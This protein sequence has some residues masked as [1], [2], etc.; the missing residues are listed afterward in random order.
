MTVPATR[1]RAWRPTFGRSPAG[2]PPEGD[3]A[4]LRRAERA[5][6]RHF[7]LHL[8]LG[9]LAVLAAVVPSLP[10][11]WVLRINL[12]LVVG[13]VALSLVLLTGLV[14]Q[15]S[16]AQGSMMGIGAF[17]TA[18]IMQEWGWSFWLAGVAAVLASSVIG[19]AVGLPALRLQGIS[20]AIATWSFALFAD[21]FIL[22]QQW[23]TAGQ[24]GRSARPP[25]VFGQDLR[26]DVPAF[27]V[28]ALVTA[29][30]LVVVR[31]LARG[32]TGRAMVAVRDSED[33]ARALGVSVVRY[34]LAAFSL[35]SAVAATAGVLHAL[36]LPTLSVAEYGMFTSV[37][38]LAV[39]VIGGIESVFGAVLAGLFQHSLPTLLSNLIGTGASGT[40]VD[41]QRGAVLVILLMVRPKGIAS[42]FAWRRR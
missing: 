31:N 1:T 7:Q 20:L 29:C 13:L 23:L 41:I 25:V 17:A 42:F 10:G 2:A 32:A 5:S 24:A 8:A 39:S 11:H 40:S 18:A 36:L 9:A 14:G 35:A 38:L 19:L 16:L 15:I 4:A 30:W 28:V 27:V 22:R 21:R 6:S 12:S 26:D 37:N 33:G 34:K 3:H